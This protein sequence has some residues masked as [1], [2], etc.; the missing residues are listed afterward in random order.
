MKLL[1]MLQ[2]TVMNRA[3]YG[4][5]VKLMTIVAILQ[6]Q[7]FIQNTLTVANVSSTPHTHT[8]HTHAQGYTY[9]ATQYTYY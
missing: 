2:K 3:R 5:Q 8:L 1:R 6:N 7:L 4:N 9:T